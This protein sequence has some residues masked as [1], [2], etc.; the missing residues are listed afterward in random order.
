MITKVAITSED[1]STISGH[2][3]KCNHFFVYEIDDNG[4]FTKSS[5]ELNENQILHYSFHEDPSPEPQNPLFEMNMILAND[6][7]EGA[8]NNLARQRVAAHQIMEQDPDEAI[9]KLVEGTLQAYRVG[10]HHHH[11]GGGCGCGSGGG[12]HHHD[13]DDHGGCGCSTDESEG[14]GCHSH[15]EDHHHG[16]CGC[17]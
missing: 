10:D 15:E 3:G 16:G 6:L 5:L 13:H 2:I 1:K 12:H 11:G 7:G 8:V 17:H 9:K 4:S 14:C